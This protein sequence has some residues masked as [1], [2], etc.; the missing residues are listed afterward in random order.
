MALTA[1][2]L[3]RSLLAR[4]GLLDRGSA[5]I[6]DTLER[7]VGLQAQEPR[8][9]YVAL[10]SRLRD[11]DPGELSAL[12][13]GGQAV[14]AGLMRS[15]IHLVTARDFDALQPLMAAPMA[16]AFRS[17]W[18]RRLHGAALGDVLSLARPLIETAPMTR[19]DLA[20]ALAP[21]FPDAEP[22]ALAQVV[23]YHEPLVQLPPR[24]LWDRSGAARWALREPAGE[25][26]GVEDVVRRYLAAFGPATTAD[27]RT[28]SR[29]TGLR[30][31]VAGMDDL[32]RLDGGLLDIADAPW[33]DED[34]PAPPRFLPEYDNLLL[35]HAD[36]S[37]VVGARIAPPGGRFHGTLL[38]DGFTAAGWSYGDGEVRLHHPVPR[39]A[40]EEVEA[41]AAA[42]AAF[43]SS[44]G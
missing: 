40:R 5:S 9:P 43:L 6:P 26:I 16:A 27:I 22:A 19:A 24:G 15:T 37:R 20:A 7:L 21:S 34:H 11:F 14:R 8:D 18:S 23:T 44:A 12:L 41:E 30:E 31:V 3:N 39:A 17:S 13:A 35:S 33:P 36:R 4:Q 25:P 2:A 28:W 42:L 10:W 1:R 29:L 38:I 32:V